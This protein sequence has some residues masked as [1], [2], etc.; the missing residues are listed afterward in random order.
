MFDQLGVLVFELLDLVYQFNLLGVVLLS[1]DSIFD[2]AFLHI[3]LA[4]HFL[5]PEVL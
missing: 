1:F 4:N 5:K 2:G 3:L